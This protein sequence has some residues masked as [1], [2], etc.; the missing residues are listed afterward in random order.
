[1]G[2]DDKDQPEDCTDWQG[3]KW[4]LVIANEAESKA[5]HPNSRFTAPV[6]IVPQSWESPDGV[7]IS[8]VVFG[9]R[10][11]TIMPALNWSAGVYAGAMMGSATI[12]AAVGIVGKVRRDPMAMLPFCGY[13]MGD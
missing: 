11:A 2:A 6:R 3:K 10:R 1:M 12:A 9:G 13:Y 5:A 8:A 7:P 4:T